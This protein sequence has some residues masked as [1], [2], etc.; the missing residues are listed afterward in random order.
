MRNTLDAAELRRWAMQCA[1]RAS[2][3]D[4]MSDERQRLLT[5]REALLSLAVDADW[6]KGRPDTEILP[7]SPSKKANGI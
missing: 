5:M 2:N 1:A 6:L 7:R 3:E 4:C